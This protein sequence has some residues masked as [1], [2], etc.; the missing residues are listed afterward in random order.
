MDKPSAI[1]LWLA[2][3]WLKYTEPIPV[4]REQLGAATEELVRGS[5]KTDL[6]IGLE[7]I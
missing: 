3:L 7:P 1:V 4:V 2:M 6:D 5:R